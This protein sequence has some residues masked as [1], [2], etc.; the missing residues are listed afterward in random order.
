[1]L[2]EFQEISPIK[3]LEGK[4]R[5][6][7]QMLDSTLPVIALGSKQHLLTQIFES[8]RKPFYKWGFSVELNP[9]AYEE[10]HDYMQSRFEVRSK[11]ISL[12]A[13]K[14]LQDRMKRVPES[15]NRLC[16]HLLVNASIKA[17]TNESID[18]AIRKITEDSQSIYSHLF[19]QFSSKE[20]QVLVSVA[21]FGALTEPTGRK[22]LA[23]MPNISKS[24][25]PVLLKKILDTGTLG[26][27]PSKDGA[28]EYF[29]E[30]SFFEDYIRRFH[31][32]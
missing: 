32:L 4:L 24:Q 28:L 16:E 20:R 19:V 8:P 1:V 30:D 15:I 10:Y 25:V 9:I 12:E 3:G 13:S 14:Y 31:I 26:T 27:R 22:S 5:N 6:C 11:Q 7:L 2:D 23:S 18:S 29:I 17:I 21:S